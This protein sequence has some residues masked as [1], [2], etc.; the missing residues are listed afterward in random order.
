M[1]TEMERD[2]AKNLAQKKDK[3]CVCCHKKGCV[4]SDCSSRQRDMARA[5]DSGK[6]FVDRKQTAAITDDDINGA[7]IE[8]IF[9]QEPRLS[10]L[11]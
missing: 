10:C 9:K 5:K 6:P 7:V 4:M 3:Q 2:D 11:P 1:Q 8:G